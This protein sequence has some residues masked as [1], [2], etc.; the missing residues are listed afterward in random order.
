MTREEK[1][2]LFTKIIEIYGTYSKES[3]SLVFG[4]D[5]FNISIKGLKQVMFSNL[6]THTT[7][8]RVTE[9]MKT[10]QETQINTTPSFPDDTISKLRIDLL[11]EELDEFKTAIEHR[12]IVGVFDALID[13]QYVL[14]GAFQAFGLAELKEDGFAEVHASNMS[15]VCL[16]EYI[17]DKTSD[18]IYPIKHSFKRV[19]N[20]YVCLREDGKV[21][22]S[23]N[24]TPPN[25]K[26]II[27][28]YGKTKRMG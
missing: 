16:T 23:I 27:E 9:F 15:K 2:E 25:L 11:Q 1:E 26:K 10:F 8:E 21:L 17:K 13:L 28:D 19:A 24:Y 4:N 12:D 3:C 22:K 5:K 18:S 7:I 20:G 6:F 14:D